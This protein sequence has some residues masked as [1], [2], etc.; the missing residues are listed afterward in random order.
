MKTVKLNCPRCRAENHYAVADLQAANGRVQCSQCRHAFTVARKPKVQPAAAPADEGI[1]KEDLIHAK[2]PLREKLAR[3]KQQSADLAARH[4]AEEE[5]APSQKNAVA[6]E[7]D[8]IDSRLRRQRMALDN[9]TGQAMPFKLYADEAASAAVNT[10]ASAIEALLQRSAAAPPPPA[11]LPSID[12][13][14]KSAQ[15]AAAGNG[16]TQNIHIQA[17]SL[18]FN[19]VSGREGGA[20]HLP[21]A[22]AKLPAV[23]DQP[24]ADNAPAPAPA[25]SGGG[26][27]AT[28]SEFNWTLAS[29]V[30]LT[31]LIMQLFYYL[32]IM[33]H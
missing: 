18:V 8:E 17:E 33:K 23:I 24:A 20:L 19:L 7:L 30:A 14:L 5:R 22:A 27:A 3:L 11:V 13:L 15:S 25:A 12:T 29:L 9:D 32:L 21:T 28:H 2:M 10:D 6:A 26:A 16:Q 31:V 1:L 4:E